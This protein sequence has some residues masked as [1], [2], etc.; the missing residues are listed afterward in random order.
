M[1]AIGTC[2]VVYTSIRLTKVYYGNILNPLLISAH[3]IC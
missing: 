3:L 2:L 1:P